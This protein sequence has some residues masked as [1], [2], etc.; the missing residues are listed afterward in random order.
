MKGIEVWLR[1]SLLRG[2]LGG[3]GVEL[4]EGLWGVESH[5][6]GGG[7]GEPGRE[8]DVFGSGGSSDGGVD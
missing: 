5:G 6:S 7:E 3:E 8:S 4:E 2:A 1:G